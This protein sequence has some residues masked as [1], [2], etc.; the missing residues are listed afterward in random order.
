MS[1]ALDYNKSKDKEQGDTMWSSYSDLFMVLSLVFLLLYVTASLRNGTF[2]IQK[3]LELQSMANEAEDLRSQNKVYNT[4]KD[5]YLANQSTEDEQKVYEELMNKLT[6]LEDKATEEKNELRRQMQENDQKAKALNQYQQII[7]NIV[8]ANM[9]AKAGMKTRE[10]IIDKKD[11]EIA[12]KKVEIQQ[13]SEIIEEQEKTISEKQQLISQ[14]EMDIV[15]KQ[16][17][18]EQNQEIIS[19]KKQELRKKSEEIDSLSSV[20]EVKQKKIE[21]NENEIKKI[22]DVLQKQMKTLEESRNTAKISQAEYEKQLKTLKA[23]SQNQVEKLSQANQEMENQLQSVSGALS[24][25]Q[26]KLEDASKQMAAKEEERNRLTAEL[27]DANDRYQEEVKGLKDKYE[28][29]LEDKKKEFENQL[30][31]EKLSGKEKAKR[32]EEFAKQMAKEAGDLKDKLA[33]LSDKIKDNEAKLAQAEA[34]QGKFKE[35]ADKLKEQN[36]ELA[37]DLKEAKSVA[38]ARK[39][40]AR[41]IKNALSKAGLKAD[42]D[43]RTGDVVMTFGDEYFDTGRADLKD[44]MRS[45]LKNFMP[46]YAESLFKNRNIAEKIKSVEVVGFASPTYRGKFVDP[47]SLDVKDREAVNYNLDLS[48]NRAKEI[49]SFIFDTDNLRYKYQEKLLP[50]VKVTGRSFLAEGIEGR[51]AQ[52]GMPVS[53]YCKKYDCQKDQKVIIRFNLD[54]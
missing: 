29:E 27:K 24:D 40:L 46:V 10:E 16:S 5:D 43:A 37:K 41:D 48:Y 18:I 11:D 30:A 21:S 36:Q 32:Q 26:S 51:N 13:K 45:M 54:N 12:E 52:T 31:K 3:S 49:F 1:M 25:A 2:S 39:N 20:L 22:N 42:V 23:Q 19:Q 9:L 6:L 50:L 15:Q 34:D 53:E 8:N 14:Q 7:R 44:G 33:N 38:D 17:E 28:G 35:Y 4:L 47:S